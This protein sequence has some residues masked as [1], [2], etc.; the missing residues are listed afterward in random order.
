MC[1]SSRAGANSAWA[2]GA[3]SAVLFTAPRGSPNSLHAL[4]HIL[5][6]RRSGSAVVL[7]DRLLRDE[8]EVVPADNVCR[9]RR[10]VAYGRR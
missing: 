3:R 2:C 1:I 4:P 10:R 8:V 7:P 5:D 9:P 6:M